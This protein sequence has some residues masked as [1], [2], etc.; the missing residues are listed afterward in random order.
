MN[1]I[2]AIMTILLIIIL[3]P[4]ILLAEFFILAGIIFFIVVIVCFAI[5]VADKISDFT[6]EITKSK[7]QINKK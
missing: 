2:S 3:S 4:V 6:Y 7:K 1:I 5:A